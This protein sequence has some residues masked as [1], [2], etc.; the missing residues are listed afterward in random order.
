MFQLWDTG[1]LEVTLEQSGQCSFSSALFLPFTHT[2]LKCAFRA[3]FSTWRLQQ[4]SFRDFSVL[5]LL[6][7]FSVSLLY[8]LIYSS[9]LCVASQKLYTQEVPYTHTG[10]S[11][12]ISASDYQIQQDA[13][14]YVYHIDIYA[15]KDFSFPQ[16]V[17]ESLNLNEC[18]T[19]S[20]HTF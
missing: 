6:R 1:P 19:Q 10:P 4:V 18:C 15:M 14:R 3:T 11:Y 20:W 2:D 9:Y 13:G 5:F 7:T 17:D 12:N 8:F 16:L